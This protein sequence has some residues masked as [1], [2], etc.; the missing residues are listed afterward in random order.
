MSREE[1]TQDALQAIWMR[2]RETL[3]QRIE[4]LERAAGALLEDRLTPEAR[5]T[6]RIEAH[7]LAGSLGTFGIPEGSE[8]ARAIEERLVEDRHFEADEV[9]VLCDHVIRLASAF[10]RHDQKQRME[11]ETTERAASLTVPEPTGRP[12]ASEG[13]SAGAPRGESRRQVVWFVGIDPKQARRLQDRVSARG[14]SVTLYPDAVQALEALT[15]D[16]PEILVVAVCPGGRASAVGLVRATRHAHPETV[17][18]ALGATSRLDDRVATAEA[19]ADRYLSATLPPEDIIA[20]IDAVETDRGKRRSRILVVDDDRP[21]LELL[22]DALSPG[23]EAQ[24]LDDPAG[25]WAAMGRH[26][27]DLVV[28][29]LDMPQV[30]GL[31]LCRALRTDPRWDTLPVVFVS[32]H[33]DPA[34]RQRIWDAGGDD[35]LRKP[36]DPERL[37]QCVRNRLKRQAALS[38]SGDRDPESGLPGAVSGQEEAARILSIA[39][40]HHQVMAVALVR[41]V[42]EAGTEAAHLASHLRRSLLREDLLF[43][44]SPDIAIVAYGT[45]RE[46]LA[47]RVQG[48]VHRLRSTL[49]ARCVAAVSAYPA[50]GDTLSRLF[51]SAEQILGSAGSAPSGTVLVGG[52]SKGPIE[53]PDIVVVDDDETVAALLRQTLETNGYSVTWIPDGLDAVRL[54]GGSA[55]RLRPRLVLL[56]V[57]LPGLDGLSI[58]RRLRDEGRLDRMKVIM[59]TVR[60]LEA[61]VVKA[62][63][64]GADDHVSKPFSTPVLLQRIQKAI[65]R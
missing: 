31:A 55:P 56:D 54:L 30:N 53:R 10:E 25:F 45:D 23:H 35:F 62:L 9:A 49:D 8:H 1:L 46:T 47:D 57:N 64:A 28:L 14:W 43:T 60:S 18:L 50:D 38:R 36:I 37:N 51:Q 63:D 34:V 12:D 6:A 48:A 27:P 52:G 29:D 16:P 4:V 32:A 61:E 20:T 41:C 26:R 19:G 33:G 58:L 59:L 40:R 44:R 42:S 24:G 11:A 3:Q 22:V 5:S 15:D 13:G 2:S 17:I 7:R 39:K 21:T 65:G